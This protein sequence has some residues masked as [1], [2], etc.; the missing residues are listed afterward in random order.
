MWRYVIHPTNK[1]VDLAPK[2]LIGSRPGGSVKSDKKKRSKSKK[3]KKLNTDDI[4]QT[5]ADA[6]ALVAGEFWT[7]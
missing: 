3:D 1:L 6:Q 2:E 4:V 5:I 7:G